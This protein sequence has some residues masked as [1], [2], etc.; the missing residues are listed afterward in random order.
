MDLIDA[1]KMKFKSNH[2]NNYYNVMPFGL[3]NAGP[4]YKRLMDVVFLRK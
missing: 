2:V 3:K 4:T 1:P